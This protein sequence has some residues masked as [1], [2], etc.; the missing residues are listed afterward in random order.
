MTDMVN[1]QTSEGLTP[2]HMAAI[3]GHLEICQLLISYGADSHIPD[4]C[5]FTALDFAEF[6]GHERVATLLRAAMKV[7]PSD[8]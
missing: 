5:G 8:D 6:Q 3:K 1:A 2:L 4:R 7:V